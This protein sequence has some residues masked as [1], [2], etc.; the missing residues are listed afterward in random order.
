MIYYHYALSFSS[1][2]SS[3]YLFLSP[4]LHLLFSVEIYGRMSID[5]LPTPAKFHYIL[6]LRDLY[7]V[8]ST[9]SL[10]T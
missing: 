10:Y 8:L 6:I 3:I 4:S 1:G 9:V 2:F 5:L 7:K